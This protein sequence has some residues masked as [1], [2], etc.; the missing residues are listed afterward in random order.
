MRYGSTNLLCK[1]DEQLRNGA[2]QLSRNG[3]KPVKVDQKWRDVDSFFR[4]LR[5][6][7]L[8]ILSRRLGNKFGRLSEHY[9]PFARANFGCRGI[10][11]QKVNNFYRT[12]WSTW[13]TTA[14]HLIWNCSTFVSKT[15]V[16]TSEYPFSLDRRYKRKFAEITKS[17]RK[18][19]FKKYF[20]EWGCLLR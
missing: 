5:Y 6:Y 16:T 8:G 20:N 18:K 17:I 1:A 10:S 2:F 12:A 15:Q 3:K 11:V 7:A 9:A 14:F 13:S 19:S 4:L